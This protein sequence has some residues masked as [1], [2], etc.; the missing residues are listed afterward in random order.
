MHARKAWNHTTPQK[1]PHSTMNSQHTIEILKKYVQSLT[2]QE[3]DNDQLQRILLDNDRIIDWSVPAQQLG[4]TKRQLKRWYT[5]T[6]Q[7]QT[8]EKVSKQDAKLLQQMIID[9]ILNGQD[10][11]SK[12]AQAEMHAMLSKKY[13]K[14]QFCTAYTN[15]KRLAQDK[16]AK[17]QC[18]SLSQLTNESK[19]QSEMDELLGEIQKI[20]SLV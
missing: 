10:Y 14:F 13:E 4:L 9:R 16:V 3:V 1:M 18:S 19:S 8:H 17:N 20:M 12:P 2:K 11:R 15:A 5:E 6:Y 7:R